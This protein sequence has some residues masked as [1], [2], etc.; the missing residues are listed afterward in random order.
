[1]A[2]KKKAAK[3]TVKRKRSSSAVSSHS[4]SFKNLISEA[5]KG[6][7]KRKKPKKPKAKTLASLQAYVHKVSEWEREVRH[8]ASQHKQFLKLKERVAKM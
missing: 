3:K 7:F 2:T 6:G 1:M 4:L 5:R 8:A